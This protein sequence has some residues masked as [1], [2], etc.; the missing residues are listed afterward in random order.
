MGNNVFVA[1]HSSLTASIDEISLH[2]FATLAFNCHV[3]SGSDD[4]SGLS[5]VNPTIPSKFKKP[6]TAPIE[7]Q[8]HAILGASTIVFPGCVIAEGSAVGAGSV[9]TK[10]TEPWGIYIG[11]PARR[12][13]NRSMELLELEA[14]YLKEYPFHADEGSK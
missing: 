9:V 11:A 7:I 1:V 4:Y 13:K 10:S 12:V 3:F 6:W 2:D 8:R 14:Q 5:M